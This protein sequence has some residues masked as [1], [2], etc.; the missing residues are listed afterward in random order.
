MPEKSDQ[1]K[2]GG[3]D[4][5]ES[6]SPLDRQAYLKAVRMELL[7]KLGLPEDTRPDQVARLLTIKERLDK[8]KK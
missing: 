3:P 5:G 8:L 6:E 4:S 2:S 1:K 7:K